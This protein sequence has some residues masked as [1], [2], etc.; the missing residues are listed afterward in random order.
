MQFFPSFLRKVMFILVFFLS[1]TAVMIIFY[2]LFYNFNQTQ[3]AQNQAALL[4][5]ITPTYPPRFFP[6]ETTSP[7]EPS[8]PTPTLVLNSI[9]KLSTAGWKSVANNGVSFLIPKDASCI[10]S[11]ELCTAISTSFEFEGRNLPISIPVSVEVYEGNSRREQ[12]I[13]NHHP[14]LIKSCNPIF[15]EA[16]FGSVNALQIAA[17]GNCYDAGAI[18]A[19]AGNKMVIFWSLTYDEQTKK[20]N[21]FPLRDTIISTVQL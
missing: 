15:S 19:V 17:D 7:T 5:S 20:I 8:T 16:M 6:T 9:P 18:V 4:P 11:D 10:G 14:E 2:T 12:F 1:I 3:V 13:K 21:R